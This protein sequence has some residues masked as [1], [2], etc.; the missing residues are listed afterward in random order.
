MH[1]LIRSLFIYSV[2]SAKLFKKQIFSILLLNR[3]FFYHHVSYRKHASV[4][5][6]LQEV[7]IYE[8]RKYRKLL[9]VLIITTGIHYFHHFE[10]FCIA[11]FVLQI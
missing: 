10:L 11:K 6:T 8:Q 2:K 5:R 4:D 7:N 3:S 1:L 9:C